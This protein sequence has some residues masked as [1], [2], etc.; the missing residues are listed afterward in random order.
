MLISASKGGIGHHLVLENKLFSTPDIFYVLYTQFFRK[1][2]FANFNGFRTEI[3]RAEGIFRKQL[4]L[5]YTT[6]HDLHN[7]FSLTFQ[8]NCFL[9]ACP[10]SKTCVKVGAPHFLLVATSMIAV[11]GCF[12]LMS[13]KPVNVNASPRTLPENDSQIHK[14][15]YC[16]ILILEKNIRVIRSTVFREREVMEKSLPTWQVCGA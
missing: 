1:R 7:I 2:S 16:W 11:T 14:W 5:Q 13:F 6:S 3:V 4:L 10:H 9:W 8:M 12:P 15:K